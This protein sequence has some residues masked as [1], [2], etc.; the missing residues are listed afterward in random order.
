MAT[1]LPDMFPARVVDPCGAMV[2]VPDEDLLVDS[3]IPIAQA[4]LA[5]M[6]HE[7][8][9]NP[10]Q[11]YQCRGGVEYRVGEMLPRQQAYVSQLLSLRERARMG[12]IG[13][14]GPPGPAGPAGVAGVAGPAGVIGPIGPIGPIGLTGL[15]GPL[16]SPGEAGWIDF[17]TSALG[18]LTALW[19][20]AG[21]VETLAVPPVPP[22]PVPAPPPSAVGTTL[23]VVRAGGTIDMP[24][25]PGS[26]DDPA[27][28][29][30]PTF[31]RERLEKL[32]VEA[33]RL[34][35]L[36]QAREA[37]E[38]SQKQARLTM[39]AYERAMMA[40]LMA[41]L[42]ARRGG[43]AMPFGQ[44]QLSADYPDPNGFG[45]P[46][47]DLWGGIGDVAATIGGSLLA[48]W[49]ESMMGRMAEP[50]PRAQVP[51]T[52]APPTVTTAAASGLF[53]TV[54]T[55]DVPIPEFSVIGPDGKCHT[56]L[57]ARPKG[58][59][60]NKCNVSGRRRRHHHHPR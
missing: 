3:W 43:E 18:A 42:A 10:D 28:V 48:D 31:E 58:W 47:T 55:R 6:Y 13:P 25:I 54:T 37:Q 23:E 30:R 38:D 29:W 56:W 11:I 20:Q 57:H 7:L 50:A 24:V 21:D 41:V 59:K 5:E 4:Q 1:A 35:L 8:V 12:L 46:G 19:P 14:P 36:Y 9:W 45:Y 15:A 52:R 60:I 53:R 17:L 32:A 26:R 2:Y 40:Y 33:Y 16:P 39:E 49:L 22:A 51:A 44:M 27:G 34:W